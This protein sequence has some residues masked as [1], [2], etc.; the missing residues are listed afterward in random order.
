MKR[1]PSLLFV[2][3]VAI[4][5]LAGC[6]LFDHRPPDDLRVMT[7][8][9]SVG[10]D[11]DRVL[12]AASMQ[13]VPFA[14]LLTW[15]EVQ[16][17]DFAVRAAALAEEIAAVKPHV[18]GLQEITTFRIQDPGDLVLG[19]TVP[20]TQ[21][22]YD[23]LEILQDALIARGLNY[24]VAGIVADTEAEMP[25]LTG[26][27]PLSFADVRFQDF[28]VVL[29]RAEVKV[30]NVI[31]KTYD[32][33]LPVYFGSQVL[34]VLRGYVAFDAVLH[35]RPFRFV[36]THLEPVTVPELQDL[37]L[38][39]AD[40]LMEAAGDGTVIVLGDLNTGPGD[41]TYIHLT[42]SGF[43]DAWFALHPDDPGFT[44][45][46]FPNLTTGRTPDSRIDLVLYR[47]GDVTTLAPTA[48]RI[49][50]GSLIPGQA[51]YPS[52]HQGLTLTFDMD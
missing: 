16:T 44:C 2:L 12:A 38:A 30:R 17:N 39:Q 7:R 25:M 11:I 33:Y 29:V 20:A 19:G 41:P 28:D 15:Q 22:V 46:F 10:G 42:A 24:K 27:D 52:D 13:E 23:Y 4:V 49:S 48:A 47:N 6:S 3:L 26:T 35:G 9:V 31:A 50:G 34:E 1:N 8:N 40:E 21:V 14:A 51:F 18:I 36:S 5:L 37:Q 45:C 32:A 43:S